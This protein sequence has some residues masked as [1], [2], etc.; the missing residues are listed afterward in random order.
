MRIYNFTQ[1]NEISSEAEL[2]NNFFA[3]ARG[4]LGRKRLEQEKALILP[5]CQAIHMFFMQ[6][7]IDVVFVDGDR[8]VIG[9]IKNIQPFTLSPIF[10]R[11]H[12]AIELA[13]GS[14]ERKQIALGDVLVFEEN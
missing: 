5:H 6:F 10:F 12:F 1:K 14:I 11:A 13:A 7:P 9:L 8:R 2:A 3:R 4:L